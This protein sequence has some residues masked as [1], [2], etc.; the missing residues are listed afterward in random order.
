MRNFYLR[1]QLVAEERHSFYTPRQLWNHYLHL[2]ILPNSVL[3]FVEYYLVVIAYPWNYCKITFMV[4]FFIFVYMGFLFRRYI[5][6]MWIQMP[7]IGF[8]AI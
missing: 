3:P 4:N 6:T 1:L 5:K 8:S 7:S 2:Y